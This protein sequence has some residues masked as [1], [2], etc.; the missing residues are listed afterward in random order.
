MA[1]RLS[2]NTG[3]G[4]KIMANSELFHV[5]FLDYKENLYSFNVSFG[6]QSGYLT[7]KKEDDD[8]KTVT[9]DLGFPRP[10]GSNNDPT[11]LELARYV[12]KNHVLIQEDMTK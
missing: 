8:I 1:N 11:L 9:I 6:K 10:L 7:I 2:G 3:T 4:K 12:L 5:N